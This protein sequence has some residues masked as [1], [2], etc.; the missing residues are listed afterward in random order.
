MKTRDARDL[1]VDLFS[2]VPELKRVEANIEDDLWE[3]AGVRLTIVV[4]DE[5]REVERK[6]VSLLVQFMI[7]S[8]LAVDFIIAP[9][10]VLHGRHKFI[11][12]DREALPA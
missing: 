3:R 9:E 5:S 10:R 4:D 11:V 1:A 6:V 2:R 8:E 7:D 12:Y